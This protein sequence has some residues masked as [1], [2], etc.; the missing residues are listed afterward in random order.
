M[1]AVTLVDLYASYPE[2]DAERKT[3]AL[4]W[5]GRLTEEWFNQGLPNVE[6]FHVLVHHPGE[7]SSSL[8][9]ATHIGDQADALAHETS[10]T[11]VAITLTDIIEGVE[12][13]EVWTIRRDQQT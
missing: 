7:I 13:Y 3:V 10:L 1:P 4:G 2:T 6:V 11:P 9:R 12:D 5:L 8:P